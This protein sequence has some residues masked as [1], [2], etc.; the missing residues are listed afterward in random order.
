M[1]R[2]EIENKQVNFIGSWKLD[3]DNICKN[4]IK[5]FEKNID[6]QKDGSTGDG[7]KA[8]IKKTTDINIHPK[9]LKDE[10]FLDIKKLHYLKKK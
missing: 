5:F 10:N 4:I 1:K 3:N 6:L 9:N 2:L 8:N 7:K